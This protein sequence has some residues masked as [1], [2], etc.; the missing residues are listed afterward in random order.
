MV[1]LRLAIVALVL[2]AAH[3]ALGVANPRG[4]GVCTSFVLPEAYQ[5]T[6]YIVETADGYK[7]ALERVAKN[8]TTPTLGPVFL[9]HGIMEGGD[10]WVLN[11]PD[12]SLAF[13]MADAG[14]DVFIGNG[15]ASMFSSHNLFSRADT[16]FWD[17]SMDE[18]VVHDLPALLTYVNTLTDKRIF[19]VGYSQGTQVAFAALSQSGNK[20]A[21]LIE[22]AAM[23]APIAYLNHF[24]VFFGKR[25]SGFSVSQVLLRSGISEFSLAA[26]RQVLNI[27]CRQSNLDCIDDLLTLFTGPNCCVNVSRMSYYNMYEMQS[28]SMRNL[29]HLAQLVRSGRFAKFDFQVPGNIDHY[30]VLIPPSY[31]LS[32][33]P[34]SIPMLLVYGGRDELADQAD[35]QHLIRDLHRTSVEVLFL[36]RYAHADFVL[37]INANVDVYPHVLE[38]FQSTIGNNSSMAPPRG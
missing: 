1:S 27:I 32:T 20:A 6:E 15:R 9:Y 16:R 4:L 21:S 10:I 17:W 36:P 24:R 8:C 37:G 25:S 7:L 13:I 30:G 18:L 14:Y 31:S 12:E 38:F 11:P 5:C 28:T 33:I 22:R 26:G 2:L 34:V 29:A 19:F 23:L 35:V 3:N